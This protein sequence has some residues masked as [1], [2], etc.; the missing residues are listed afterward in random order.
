MLN[1]QPVLSNNV[2]FTCD[3]D[4]VHTP[5]NLTIGGKVVPAILIPNQPK[6]KT[7]A[8]LMTATAKAFGYKNPKVACRWAELTPEDEGVCAAHTPGGKQSGLRILYWTGLI[9]FCYRSKIPAAT[10]VRDLLAQKSS[11]LAHYGVAFADCSAE[12]GIE[13]LEQGQPQ[14]DPEVVAAVVAPLLAEVKQQH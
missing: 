3:S 7:I 11:D 6:D 10:V 8:F 1:I 14:I 13:R 9:K 5:F 2:Q 4:G 12:E